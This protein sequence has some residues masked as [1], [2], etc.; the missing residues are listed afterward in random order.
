MPDKIDAPWSADEV[1]VIVEG[2]SCPGLGGQDVESPGFNV[3]E[4][5]HAGV[6]P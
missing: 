3:N 1:T 5:W 4:A 2:T 6:D